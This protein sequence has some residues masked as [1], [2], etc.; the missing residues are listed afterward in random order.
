M[1]MRVLLETLNEISKSNIDYG[2]RDEA[3]KVVGREVDKWVTDNLNKQIINLVDSI[4][5]NF[6]KK[7]YWHINNMVLERILFRINEYHHV[8]NP[9]HTDGEENEN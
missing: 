7:Y 4:A 8:S 2:V 6:D 5:K 1:S 3:L 9:D